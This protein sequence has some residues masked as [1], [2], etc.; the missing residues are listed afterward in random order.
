MNRPADIELV[1]QT[2][3]FLDGIFAELMSEHAVATAEAEVLDSEMLPEEEE[4]D[5][6][7]D[8]GFEMQ[9]MSFDEQED[10]NMMHALDE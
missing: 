7:D 5:L 4:E 6:E 9:S 1:H 10:G 2:S 8:D 3:L